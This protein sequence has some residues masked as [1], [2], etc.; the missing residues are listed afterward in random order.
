MCVI[1]CKKGYILASITRPFIVAVLGIA[2][3][4]AILVLIALTHRRGVSR[5]GSGRQ[6]QQHPPFT[7]CGLLVADL[8]YLST[9]A[10]Y[11]VDQY[12]GA[13]RQSG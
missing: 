5:P 12:E 13:E 10:L 7:V 4:V 8:I 11:L 3:N 1:K 2:G 9:Q 6:Q